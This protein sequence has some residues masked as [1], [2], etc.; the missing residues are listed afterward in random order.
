MRDSSIW[1]QFHQHVYSQLLRTQ[2][3]KA[4]KGKSS[5]QCLFALMG[6][7]HTKALCKTLVKLTLKRAFQ[8]F[9]FLFH[10]SYRILIMSNFDWFFS[11]LFTILVVFCIATIMHICNN[12]KNASSQSWLSHSIRLLVKNFI[13]IEA[14][15][16]LQTK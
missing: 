5:H 6:I 10:S 1:D 12:L 2:I 7:E 14:L 13:V 8:Q 3:P 16:D 4:Q 15:K 11:I 9:F